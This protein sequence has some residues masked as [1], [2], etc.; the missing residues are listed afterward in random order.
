MSTAERVDVVLGL[1]LSLTRAGIAFIDNADLGWPHARPSLIT[2]VGH[3]GHDGAPW[4]KRSRRLLAQ[5]RDVANIITDAE[6]HR[7]IVHAAIEGHPYGVNMP[8][9]YDRIGLW[10]AV[11]GVLDAKGI[12]VTVVNPQTRAKFITG[13]SPNGMKPGEHKKLVLAEQRAAWG[14][15]SMRLRNHDQADA[16]G[17]AHM[18]ALHLGWPLQVEQRRRYV[19][20]VALVDWEPQKAAA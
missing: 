20:N 17:L 19:E 7:R 14:M 16:L 18:A 6:Q 10:W 11:F 1:D 15:D 13:R 2:D 4:W 9:A 3:A 12:P 8:S 5:A